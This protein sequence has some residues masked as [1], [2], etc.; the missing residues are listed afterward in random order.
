VP[1]IGKHNKKL[2]LNGLI[3]RLREEEIIGKFMLLLVIPIWFLPVLLYRLNIKSTCW[4]YWPL[5]FLLRPLPTDGRIE[6]RRHDLCL[7]W[8]NPAQR[9]LI[10]LGILWFGVSPVFLFGAK[11][12]SSLPDWPAVSFWLEYLFILD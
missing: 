3:N 6:Q 4:F 8:T 10:G 11:P 2:T 12:L 7:P 5:A 9:V 1:G